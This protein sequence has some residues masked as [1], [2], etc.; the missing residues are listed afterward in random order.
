MEK[1]VERHTGRKGKAE[2]DKGDVK[3]VGREGMKELWVIPAH[4]S[5]TLPPPPSIPLTFP[6]LPL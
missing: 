4:I 1:R 3:G 6:L 2:E 5:P